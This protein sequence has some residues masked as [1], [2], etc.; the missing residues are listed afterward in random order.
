[1]TMAKRAI[2]KKEHMIPVSAHAAGQKA[3]DSHVRGTRCALSIN[4]Y[5]QQ[6]FQ[7]DHFDRLAQ[8]ILPNNMYITLSQGIF[9]SYVEVT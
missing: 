4:M 2:R 3:S 7:E 8:D 5:A 1:M 9:N 6:S